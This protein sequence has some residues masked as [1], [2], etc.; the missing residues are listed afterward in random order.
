MNENS[1]KDE[2]LQKS[3]KLENPH[4]GHRQRV[5]KRYLESGLDSFPDH[6][7]LEMLLFFCIPQKD[8]NIIAHELM[9]KFGSFS[10]VLEADFADLKNVKGMTENAAS[11]LTMILP[12]IKRYQDDKLSEKRVLETTEDIVK[13]ISPKFIDSVNERVF[14]ICFDSK[15]ELI[16]TRLLSEGDISEA[17]LEFKKLASIVIET[18]ASKVILVHNHPNLIALPS[19]ADVEAT[20]EVF[21][22]LSKLKVMLADHII[23][24]KNGESCSMLNNPRYTNIFYGLENLFD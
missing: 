20:K 21:N 4:K 17:Q 3:K 5:L 22:F 6:N 2:M 23:V 16:C 8:T 24:A 13:Y 1:S 18:K 15:N 7:I 12:I 10:G 19:V 9:E 11:L 14:V